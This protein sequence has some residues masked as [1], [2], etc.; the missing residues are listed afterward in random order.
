VCALEIPAQLIDCLGG[1]SAP[2]C[3]RAAQQ[4]KEVQHKEAKVRETL[5]AQYSKVCSAPLTE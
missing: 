4:D 3:L 2:L 1:L 5:Q